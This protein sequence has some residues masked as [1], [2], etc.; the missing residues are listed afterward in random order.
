MRENV[1]HALI[2]ILAFVEIVVLALLFTVAI[3]PESLESGYLYS[4]PDDSMA[5]EELLVK[6]P[7]PSLLKKERWYLERIEEVKW[8]PAGKTP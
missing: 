3:S 6:I 1:Y 7:D 5:R 2:V 8:A 4:A